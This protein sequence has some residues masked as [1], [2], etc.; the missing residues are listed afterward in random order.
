[1]PVTADEALAKLDRWDRDGSGVFVACPALARLYD[2]LL[3]RFPALESLSDVDVNRF[4]VWSM[5][6]E[7]SDSIVVASCVWSRADDVRAAVVALAIERVLPC[8]PATRAEGAVEGAGTILRPATVRRYAERAGFGR[9]KVL[10]IAHDLWRFY[11]L[12]A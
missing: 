9:V 3:D 1:V 4:G 2:R 5:T 10:P 6:P 8:L 12:G 7:P 11:R